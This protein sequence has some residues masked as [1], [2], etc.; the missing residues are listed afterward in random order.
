MLRH[1]YAGPDA[2]LIV[3]FR[4]FYAKSFEGNHRQAYKDGLV[5]GPVLEKILNQ[6]TAQSQLKPE[7]KILAHSMGNRFLEGIFESWT[8]ESPRIAQ[9]ILATPDVS[10]DIPVKWSNNLSIEKITLYT[11]TAD[12]FL[13]ISRSLLDSGRA[14][15]LLQNKDLNMYATN[16]EITVIEVKNVAKFPRSIDITGHVYFLYS[17]QVRK[18]I[19]RE[20]HNIDS[21]SIRKPQPEGYFTLR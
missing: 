15:K 13:G 16:S 3:L 20:I 10:Q 21:S 17:K 6:V 1:P 14:G 9:L 5:L 12:L 11:H 4:P 2:A 18:D 7:I 19:Q 8:K